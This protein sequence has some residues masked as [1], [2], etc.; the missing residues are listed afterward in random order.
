MGVTGGNFREKKRQHRVRRRRR[1]PENND[2]LYHGIESAR[3]TQRKKKRD[4]L[5][6]T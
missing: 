4:A 1:Q 5:R 6:E 2:I 3:E